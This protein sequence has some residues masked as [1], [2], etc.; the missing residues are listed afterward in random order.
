[1]EAAISEFSW[2]AVCDSVC[3]SDSATALPGRR[4]STKKA[5][6]VSIR[7]LLEKQV[8]APWPDASVR[9]QLLVIRHC[10]L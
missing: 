3:V 5:G 4:S 10:Y 1:M 9:L 6:G 8:L 2:A 7:R